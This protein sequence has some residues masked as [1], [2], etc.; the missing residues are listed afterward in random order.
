[1]YLSAQDEKKS[2]TIINPVTRR[3][4]KLFS[5]KNRKIVRL[6][7]NFTALFFFLN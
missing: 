1:M 2:K 4:K 5:G 6:F 3:M 7:I